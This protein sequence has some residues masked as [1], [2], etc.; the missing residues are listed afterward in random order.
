MIMVEGGSSDPVGR[1]M[2]DWVAAR[3]PFMIDGADFGPCAA[4]G[5]M[6]SEGQLLGA[7]LFT[8]HQP[9]FGNIEVSFASAS[10]RWLTKSALTVIL[11]YPFDQLRVG[12]ITAITP[13]QSAGARQFLDSFGFKR[14]GVVRSGFG[15]DDAII[16]GL[17]E[18]EW[19]RSRF[20]LHRVDP[21]ART[22]GALGVQAQAAHPA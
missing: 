16:S 6:N 3:I 19:R 5:T 14:E 9:R 2:A 21:P 22:G 17:L 12:R 18:K 7:V 11:S 20:N 15:T 13:K 1:Y 8:N 10:P 4:I